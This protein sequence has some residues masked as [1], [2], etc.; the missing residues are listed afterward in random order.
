MRR[1]PALTLYSR[2]GC[3]LCEQMKAVIA[4]VGRRVP[5]EI[6]EVDVATDPELERRYGHEIPVL[7]LDGREVAK[8]RITEAQLMRL[9]SLRDAE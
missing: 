4:R 6:E 1:V 9:V 2:A 8:H 7:V 5:L 3:H